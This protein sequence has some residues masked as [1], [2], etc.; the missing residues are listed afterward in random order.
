MPCMRPSKLRAC[1][2]ASDLSVGEQQ[3][4][5]SRSDAP[6]CVR[7]IG[8]GVRACDARIHRRI[9]PLIARR[10]SALRTRLR[11]G[12]RSS[13]ASPPRRDS[14]RPDQSSHDTPRCA[15]MRCDAQS[16]TQTGGQRAAV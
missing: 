1:A 7:G 3:L 6:A 13:R 15:L 5:A 14:V 16:R 2:R 4:C 11:S 9:A 12:R 8:G 10:S